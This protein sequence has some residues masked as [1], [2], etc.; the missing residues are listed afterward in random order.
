MIKKTLRIIPSILIF[1]AFPFSSF[2]ADSTHILPGKHTPAKKI[3]QYTEDC[4]DQ[5]YARSWSVAGQGGTWGEKA[6]H[7]P[8]G[9]I[10]R[11]VKFYVGEGG[12]GIWH[13]NE[14]TVRVR[15]CKTIV[16]YEDSKK[17]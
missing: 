7:C 15:C 9:Y 8:A 5:N 10:A 3:V 6:S 11:S 13:N 16:T 17:S 1:C 14:T 2:A 12:I 4:Q